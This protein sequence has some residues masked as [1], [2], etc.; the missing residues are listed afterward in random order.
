MDML[1]TFE[2]LIHNLFNECLQFFL[3][4]SHS[5]SVVIIWKT[6]LEHINYFKWKTQ[7]YCCLVHTEETEMIG[8]QFFCCVGTVH[9]LCFVAAVSWLKRS[10]IASGQGKASPE[11][12]WMVLCGTGTC[13]SLPPA[14]EVINM[15][16]QPPWP[17]HSPVPHP[18]ILALLCCLGTCY[19]SP[20]LQRL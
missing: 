10:V 17:S 15:H 6:T 8:I 4:K 2:C 20:I 3:S 9:E 18:A 7:G 1:H 11:Q 14:P 19:A 12:E 16:L 13:R 5:R